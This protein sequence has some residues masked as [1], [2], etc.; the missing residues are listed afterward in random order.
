MDWNTITI[1]E[2]D[3]VLAIISVTIPYFIYWYWAKS[4]KWDKRLLKKYSK[5]NYLI[6]KYFWSRIMGGTVLGGLPLLIFTL[7]SDLSWKDLGLGFQ[8]SYNFLWALLGLGGLFGLM[9]YFN[10]K[11]KENLA[12]YPQMKVQLWT[13]KVFAM[14][15]FSWVYYLLGYEFLFRGVML[16]AL[17]PLLGYWPTI[18]INASIYAFAHFPKGRNETLGAIPVGILLSMFCLGFESMWFAW[19]IHIVMSCSNS[20]FS[21]KLQKEMRFYRMK[22]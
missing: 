16:F 18:A 14:E 12:S 13:P 6:Q 9:S 8:F 1:K 5:R 11:T 2:K 21:F 10:A 19:L 4:E 15:Y 3:A 17:L 7:F 22:G 20:W